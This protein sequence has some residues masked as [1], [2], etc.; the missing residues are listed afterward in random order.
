MDSMVTG[1]SIAFVYYFY[2]ADTLK[3]MVLAGALAGLTGI[4]KVTGIVVF[5]FIGMNF[6]IVMF[7]ELRKATGRTFQ[8]ECTQLYSRRA[9]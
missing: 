8:Q 3:K 6:L 9:F 4:S 2:K 5:L 1:L 7:L